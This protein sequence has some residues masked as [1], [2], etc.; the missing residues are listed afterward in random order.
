MIV[1]NENQQVYVTEIEEGLNKF[2]Q[3]YKQNWTK[4]DKDIQ[5]GNIK[6][7]PIFDLISYLNSA[8][9]EKKIIEYSIPKINWKQGSG[10]IIVVIA[11]KNEEKKILLKNIFV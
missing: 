9:K 5:Q 2:K 10:T 11:Y 7:T 3:S 8:K 1:Y 4:Y 6:E